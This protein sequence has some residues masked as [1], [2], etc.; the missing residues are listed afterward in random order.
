MKGPTV[1]KY[2]GMLENLCEL[3]AKAKKVEKPYHSLTLGM[4]KSQEGKPKMRLKAAAGRKYLQ[5]LR[6][7]LENLFSTSSSYEQLRLNAVVFLCKV[8]DEMDNW[9]PSSSPRALEEYG[10]RHLLLYHELCI[11]SPHIY[12]V[13][14]K[15]H[16]FQHITENA[17]TNPKDIWN[18]NDENEIGDCSD[19]AGGNKANQQFMCTHLIER[20]RLSM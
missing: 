10:R 9:V 11:A 2:C 13:Y 14:P 16:L 20:F 15:H 12:Y 6:L 4:M 7:M 8:C 19:L 18:Y 3:A 17:D 1:T 5:L